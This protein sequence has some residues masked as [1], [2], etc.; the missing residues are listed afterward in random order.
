MATAGSGDVLAGM[1]GGLLAQG[2]DPLD[3]AIAGVWI[4]GRAGDVAAE[5]LS[6]HSMIAGDILRAVPEVFR[7]MEGTGKA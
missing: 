3:A 2:L 6:Q 5:R 7:E 1:I 4:H